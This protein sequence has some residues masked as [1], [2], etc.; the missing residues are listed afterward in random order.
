MI[1]GIKRSSIYQNG[2]PLLILILLSGLALRIFLSSFW[3]YQ[4]DFGTWTYWANG[5]REVGFSNFYGK[6]WCDYMPGY[7][8]VLWFLQLIHTEFPNVPVEILF[9]LPANL[10]DLGISIL[11][12]YALKRITSMRVA[13]LSSIVYFFNPAAI[14]NSVFWG[15][16]DSVHTLPI[17]FSI[18]LVL[19]K[20]FIMSGIFASLAFM[21]KPQSFVIFPILWVVSAK[22]LFN[23]QSFPK[24]KALFPTIKIIVAMIISM[25]ALTVPFMAGKMDSFGDVFIEPISLISQRFDVA[26]SQYKYAS[27]NAFNFWGMLTMWKSDA[28]VFMNIT[29]QTWGTIIF[30]LIYALILGLLFRF[31][32]T[33]KDEELGGF[34]FSIYY[35]VTLVLFGLFLFVTRAHER[36]LL[37]TIVF[38]TIIVFVRREYWL[39]YGAISSIYV[40]NM[41]Y[42]YL[43]LTHRIEEIPPAPFQV[44]VDR[45]IPGIVIL[46][47]LVF[48]VLMVDFWRSMTQVSHLQKL[49]V[50]NGG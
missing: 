2:F 28:T 36:H 39:F 31:A 25:L 6:Y 50:K 30:A 4:P 20:R 41:F 27:L 33:R 3:T 12:F 40:L 10:S 18:V 9:K 7:L 35:S 44:I 14:S 45:L 21:I 46:V 48:V 29:Y 38:L 32:V 22:T 8:Y 49:L 5:I 15:Q 23:K 17:L 19:E 34:S 47:L 42:S 26:Y 16:V 13:L 37:P 24:I 43:D 1:S 11:I